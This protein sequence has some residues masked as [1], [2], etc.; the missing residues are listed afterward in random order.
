MHHEVTNISDD[1]ESKTRAQILPPQPLNKKCLKFESSRL[2]KL[3]RP[4]PGYQRILS[5]V[6]TAVKSNSTPYWHAGT[7]SAPRWHQPSHD[8]CHVRNHQKGEGTKQ[9][10]QENAKRGSKY[11]SSIYQYII[12]YHYIPPPALR[13]SWLSRIKA[14]NKAKSC[15]EDWTGSERRGAMTL[16]TAWHARRQSICRLVKV[17]MYA[18]MRCYMYSRWVGTLKESYCCFL[19]LWYFWCWNFVISLNYEYHVSLPHRRGCLWLCWLR[20]GR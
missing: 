9:S 11:I 3:F 18:C 8:T 6:S 13:P 19:T 14:Q 5:V 16:D 10:S 17:E 12:N 7:A 20:P 15:K 2:K 4:P 1:W